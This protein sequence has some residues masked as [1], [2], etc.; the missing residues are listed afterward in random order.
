MGEGERGTAMTLNFI[1]IALVALC[2]FL[3]IVCLI[4]GDE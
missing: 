1:P 2:I 4:A 3:L